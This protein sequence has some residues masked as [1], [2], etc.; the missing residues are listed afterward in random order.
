M[1]IICNNRKFTRELF[2]SNFTDKNKD[3]FMDSEVS[4]TSTAGLL[5]ESFKRAVTLR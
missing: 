5:R 4:L 2:Q 1:N 3:E